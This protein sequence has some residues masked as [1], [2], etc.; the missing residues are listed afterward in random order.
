MLKRFIAKVVDG[1]HLNETESGEAMDVIMEGKASPPQI[2]SFLTA[3]RMKGETI[4]E[5]TGFARTMRAKAVRIRAKDGECVVDTCGT[6]GDGKGTFNIST[7]VA[8][9]AAGGGCTVAKHHNRSVSSQCGSAD[10]LEALGINSA[11]PP[12]RAETSLREFRLAFLFAP[13]F[14]PATKHALVPRREIGIRTAFNL[15]GPL[16]NPA[17]ATIHLAGLYRE[18]LLRPVA[19]VLRNLGSKAAFVVHS[20]DHCDE[21]SI[22]GK[23]N[24]CQLKDGDIETYQIE[25]EMVGLKR[26][27]LKEIQGGTPEENADILLRVLKGESGS[28]RDV[29]LLNAAALF[30]AAEKG[31]NLKDGIEMARESIDSGRAIKKLEEMIRFSNCEE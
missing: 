4:Q 31:S 27:T 13:S 12:E 15:L 10:V 18:D 19:E 5:I 23:T 30:V 9:V 6:G 26:V 28:P 22:T 29:V 11:L 3:L 8:F 25:P 24:V 21:I 17:G 20:E 16:T 1:I 14:H 2:A 7:A